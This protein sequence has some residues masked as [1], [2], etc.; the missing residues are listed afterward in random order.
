MDEDEVVLAAS[1][2]FIIIL[3]AFL[4]ANVKKT[5]PSEILDASK[6]CASKEKIDA[7]E[8]MRDLILGDVDDLNLEYSSGFGFKNFFRMS[9]CTFENILNM[10]ESKI[11]KFNTWFRKAIT[12]HERFAFTLQ[13]LAS[14]DYYGSLSN[15]FK[16]SKQVISEIVPEVCTAVLEALKDYINVRS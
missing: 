8:F 10:T 4:V 13:F 6:Y 5:A 16:I 14:E 15:N 1:S 3:W 9:F 2:T 7:T 12:A 11:R